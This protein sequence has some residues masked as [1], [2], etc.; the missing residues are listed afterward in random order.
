MA[1]EKDL[2]WTYGKS[3]NPT[4]WHEAATLLKSMQSK[5]DRKKGPGLLDRLSAIESLLKEKK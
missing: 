3:P 2:G 5:T 4:N 1:K